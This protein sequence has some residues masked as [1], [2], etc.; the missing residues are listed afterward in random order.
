MGRLR[1]AL[2]ALTLMGLA[3]PARA[4][5]VTRIAS[6][7]PADPI[8]LHLSI[9][10]DRFQERA[11]IGRERAEPPGPV[12]DAEELRYTRKRAALV[13]R[14]AVGIYRDV[15]FHFE[16]PY[17]LWDDR[18]WRYGQV[19]GFSVGPA[20][21]NRTTIGNNDIDA[22]GQP[23]LDPISGLPTTC[24]LFPVDP[25]KTMTLY[26]GGRAGDFTAGLAWGIFNDKKDD[27]KPFWLV[28]LDVTFPTATRFE[29]AKNVLDSWIATQSA[30]P[31]P[32]G[33]KIWKWD[34][35]TI[36]SRRMGPADPYVK[37]HAT[38]MTTSNDTYSNCE[39]ADRLALLEEMTA[40]APINCRDPSWEKDSR[41]QPPWVA[42][43]TFGTEVVPFQDDAQ[44]QKV[45]LDLR[46]QAD[47][48]SSQRFYNELTDMSSRIHMTEGYLSMGAFVGLYMK[49]S[50]NVALHATVSLATQ[51]PH[52]LSGESLGR[53]GSWPSP[54][55]I[56]A[57]PSLQNPNFDWRYDAPG[58]RFRLSEVSLFDISVAGV[59]EF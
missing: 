1:Q 44:H 45:T 41:A 13:P 42:G 30:K 5:E 20:G 7:E 35:Y 23:C 4:A 37:A 32:F 56:T 48:T 21:T 14:V 40:Q 43:I 33:E 58:R 11:Q 51:S 57:N 38:L 8:D 9:R 18:S 15:E 31:A 28:G 49:A 17:V 25:S 47:Y 2:T 46:L 3:G 27:T 59:L 53:N 29:P 10:F 39:Y 22:D 34:L 24:P 36:L 16:F 19:G 54:A 50:K 55:E 6:S 52:Y 12:F 26:H